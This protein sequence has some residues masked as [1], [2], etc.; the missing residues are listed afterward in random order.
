MCVVV[1]NKIDKNID[2]SDLIPCVVPGHIDCTRGGLMIDLSRMNAV[3]SVDVMDSDATVEC[4]V[5][6]EQL[7]DQLRHE[8]LFFSVDPGANA[9]IGGMV[10][11]NAS[12]TT[13]I[14]Y[15]N[16]CAN[17]KG[18]TV[19]RSSQ[20]GCCCVTFYPHLF[21]LFHHRSCFHLLTRSLVLL[22]HHRLQFTGWARRDHH[23]D[24]WT[25]KQKFGRVR[26]DQFD[27]RQ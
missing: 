23:E 8:G 17:V 26:H 10:A 9:S 1:R 14:K 21:D 5:T 4:G 22:F 25:V 20:C 11:T 19:V 16:M 2:V 12:G 15:G 24:G 6:R 7:N 27:D 13:T 18:L 3:L